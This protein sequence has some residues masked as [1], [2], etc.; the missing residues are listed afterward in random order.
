MQL[1]RHGKFLDSNPRT[2]NDPNE[3]R[4]IGDDKV[5]MDTYDSLGNV[6][7]TYTFDT[8]DYPKVSKYKWCTALY[9]NRPYAMVGKTKMKLHVLIMDPKYGTFI[10]HIDGNS[11]NNCK[12]NLRVASVSLN[13]VNLLKDGLKH[14]GVYQKKSGKWYASVQWNRKTYCSCMYNTIEEA[15]FAR[16]LIEQ[17]FIPHEIIQCNNQYIDKLTQVQKDHV[18]ATINKKFS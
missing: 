12:S 8:E 10:D 1:K 16:Y 13:N 4:F 6:N 14:K 9:R 2:I 5:E 17:I 3:F 11:L 7:Y 15:A 18:I